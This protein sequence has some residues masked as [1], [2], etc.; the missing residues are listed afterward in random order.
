MNVASI[1]VKM[2]PLEE[3]NVTQD[4]L[5]LRVRSKFWRSI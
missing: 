2:Q 4:D 1:Y 5:M 3:R